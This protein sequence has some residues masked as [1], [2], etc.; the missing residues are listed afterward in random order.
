MKRIGRRIHTKIRNLMDELLSYTKFLSNFEVCR[1]VIS[2]RRRLRSKI[3]RIMLRWSHFRFRQR[4]LYKVH[5]F[6]WCTV[7]I[8]S[9]E[10]K[11]KICGAFGFLHKK[12]GVNKTFCCPS[13]DTIVDRDVNGARNI[14]LKFLT[15]KTASVK[16]GTF[17]RLM[18]FGENEGGKNL[19]IFLFSPRIA[20]FD[21][22]VCR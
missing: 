11:S 3:D 8:S 12:L 4:S 6:P 9:E 2:G 18:K 1:M 7:M 16:T 17:P 14:L 21:K 5:E 22:S 15:E 10:F 13:C 20:S 19:C